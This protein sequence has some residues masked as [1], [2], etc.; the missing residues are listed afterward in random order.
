[1]EFLSKSI[2]VRFF[3]FNDTDVIE[4]H[5]NYCQS[6]FKLGFQSVIDGIILKCGP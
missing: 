2:Q 1:M 6:L 4:C 5:W 3:I